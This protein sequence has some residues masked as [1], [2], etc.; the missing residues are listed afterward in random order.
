MA[1]G[2]RGIQSI[3]VSGRILRALVA[4]GEAM[5]LKDLAQAADLAPAQC[6]AYLTSLRHI[7][8]VQQKPESGLYYMGPLAMRLGIGWLRSDPLAAAAIR[9]MN[10]LSIE[11]GVMALVAIWGEQGPTIVHLSEGLTA[12]ALNLRQGTLYSVSGTATGRA[13][14][15]FGDPAVVGAKIAQEYASTGKGRALGSKPDHEDLIALV[16]EIRRTG[17]ATARGLPIPGVNAVSAPVYDDKAG[18]AL[19]I[20]LVGPEKVLLVD[21][22]APAVAKLIEA[23]ASITITACRADGTLRRSI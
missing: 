2:A 8:L 9:T 19:V 17:Y 14:A 1:G 11:L 15:A 3:E 4:K 18:L 10:A 16:A 6:H 13:F 5:M 12:T 21:D 22:D 7:G 20:S 23:S